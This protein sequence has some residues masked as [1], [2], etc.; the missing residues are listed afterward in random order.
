[1][2]KSFWTGN[3]LASE[4]CRTVISFLTLIMTKAIR[5]LKFGTAL[6]FLGLCVAIVSFR[7]T[8]DIQFIE[9]KNLKTFDQLR[10]LPQFKNKVVYIDMWGT[11]CIPCIEE[12]AFGSALKD[13][14]RNKPVEYL[15]LAVDYGH[16]DDEQR[17]RKMAEEKRLTG[18]HI[19]S[20]ELYMDTWR[21]IKDSVKDMY[22]IPHYIILSKEGKIA[23]A[24]A[25]RPS[26][27][28]KLYSQ[29]QSVIDK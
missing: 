24:D 18:H 9:A 6:G 13:T 12:F 8:N 22:M 16:P 11:R 7:P 26:T 21:T 27:K 23:F 20:K 4:I 14:F 3:A 17:W 25:Q 29:L 15:Y 28:E 5:L 19:L 10:Q 1:M 2:E